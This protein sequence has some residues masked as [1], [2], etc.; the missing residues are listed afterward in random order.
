[1]YY[2]HNGQHVAADQFRL[3]VSD[4]ASIS[5]ALVHLNVTLLEDDVP[6]VSEAT[7]LLHR[8]NGTHTAVAFG[9]HNLH[10]LDEDHSK[11]EQ[12]AELILT[13]QEAPAFGV[14]KLVRVARF[15]CLS[16]P[17]ASACLRRRSA[18]RVQINCTLIV[19][20]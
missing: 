20:F 1:M 4:G 15:D 19:F 12:D 18:I 6:R 10:V 16:A 13:L 2:K 5:S 8:L 17:A 11:E 3:G 7:V 9:V 14:L